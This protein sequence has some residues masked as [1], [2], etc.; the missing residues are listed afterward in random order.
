MASRV[1][2]LNYYHQ[3]LRRLI[4][5]HYNLFFIATKTLQRSC[6]DP[7]PTLKIE[8]FCVSAVATNSVGFQLH[9]RR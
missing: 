2:P 6:H 7:A 1:H 5:N 4:K 9:I 3:F 8:Q